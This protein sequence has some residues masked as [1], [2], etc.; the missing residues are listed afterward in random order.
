MDK[1]LEVQKWSKLKKEQNKPVT[2][3][4]IELVI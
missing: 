2:S 3:K 4:D 1:F